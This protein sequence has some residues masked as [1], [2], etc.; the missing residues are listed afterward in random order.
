M[1]LD[2]LLTECGLGTRTQVKSILSEGRI[3]VNGKIEKSNKRKID[4]SKDEVYIV[5]KKLDYKPFRYY[6]MHK[7]AGYITA[8]SDDYHETVMDILPSWVIKKDLVPVGRLDKDTEG[9]LLFTNNGK[10]NHELLSPKKHVEKTYYVELEDD[11]NKE[12]IDRL[13]SGVLIL[14]AYFTKKAKVEVIDNRSINL[15]IVEGKYH[16]VKEML[17]AVENKV[18]YL[19]RIRFGSLSLG[20]LKKGE[21][22]EI[23]LEDIIVEKGVRNVEI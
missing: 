18:T 16:Q 2:K 8:T 11:I 12:A 21:V 17:K 4:L 7:P 13:K 22:I 15:T 10:L 23:E 6:I 3:K 19:K 9:L 14:D 1:R 20:D 5:D